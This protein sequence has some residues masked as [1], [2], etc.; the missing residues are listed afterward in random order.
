MT[1]TTWNIAVVD[2]DESVRRALGRLLRAA[3]FQPVDYP[4]AEQ[5]LEERQ[6]VRTDCL[7][8]DIQLGGMS[9]LDLQR[10]L[11][12]SSTAPPVILITAGEDPGTSEEARRAGCVAFFRKPVPGEP[13]LTAV[14]RAIEK[15]AGAT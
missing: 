7:V 8:L 5:F 1:E 10:K 14:R 3:G 4:S 6:R 15:S 2:D 13:L 11:A 12:T 9:G